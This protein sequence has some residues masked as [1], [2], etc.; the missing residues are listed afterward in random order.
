[1]WLEFIDKV[2]KETEYINIKKA[3]A[4]TF[5]DRYAKFYFENKLCYYEYSKWYINDSFCDSINVDNNGEEK[6]YTEILSKLLHKFKV[7]E[8][9]DNG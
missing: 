8:G 3:Y 6:F 2:I 7:E 5:D 4:I 1:M 9:N